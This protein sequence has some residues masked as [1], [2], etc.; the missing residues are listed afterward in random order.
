MTTDGILYSAGAAPDHRGNVLYAITTF[1]GIA[2]NCLLCFCQ[3]GHS[4]ISTK[5]GRYLTTYEISKIDGQVAK[6][7]SHV[8]LPQAMSAI[9]ATR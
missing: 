5:R 6:I 8:C 2:D 9:L 1:I 3:P 4:M 7:Y